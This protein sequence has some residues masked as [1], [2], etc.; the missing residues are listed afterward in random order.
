MLHIGPPN[1][2]NFLLGCPESVKYIH[3]YISEGVVL[4]GV[5]CHGL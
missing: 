2:E 4:G 3:G 1:K 5:L